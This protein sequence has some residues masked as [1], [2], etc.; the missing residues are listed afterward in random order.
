MLGSAIALVLVILVA[1]AGLI[2]WPIR[3]MQRRKRK[4]PEGSTEE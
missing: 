2:I 3:V 4:K 1:A